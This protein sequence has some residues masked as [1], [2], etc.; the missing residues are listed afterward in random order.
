MPELHQLIA[1]ASASVTPDTRWELDH[2]YDLCHLH[3]GDHVETQR[4]KNTLQVTC[5]L[6]TS[7]SESFSATDISFLMNN[8]VTFHIFVYGLL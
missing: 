3:S 2:C 7:G 4:N 5:N 6:F 1:I 8:Y